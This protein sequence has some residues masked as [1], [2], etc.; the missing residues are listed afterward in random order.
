MKKQIIMLCFGLLF[1]IS[2]F[3]VLSTDLLSAIVCFLV[4][5]FLVVISH[6][7]SKHPKNNDSEHDVSESK[8]K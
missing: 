8:K 1:I 6:N 5:A 2:G 4:G 7:N 3:I